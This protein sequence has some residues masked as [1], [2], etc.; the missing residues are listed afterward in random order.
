MHKRSSLVVLFSLL[1]VFFVS[2]VNVHAQMWVPMQRGIDAMVSDTEVIVSTIPVTPAAETAWE[3]APHY[4]YKFCPT[5]WT[6][7]EALI[8]FPGAYVPPEAYAPVARD[9]AAAGYMTFV[10]PVPYGVAI[11]NHDRASQVISDNPQVSIWSVGG[12]SLGGVAASQFAAAS[13]L[14]DGV[15]LWASYPFGDMSDISPRF[16]SIYGMN[17]GISTPDEIDGFMPNHPESTIWV[18]LEGANH[19]QFG[20]YYDNAHD[21]GSV[22]GPFVQPTPDPGDN[23]ATIT[24]EE[25]H[26]DMVEATLS[27]LNSLSLDNPPVISQ[28][29]ITFPDGQ[30]LSTDSGAPTVMRAMN[31]I[32]WIFEDDELDCSGVTA[33]LKYRAAGSSDPMAVLQTYLFNPAAGSGAFTA[34]VSTLGTGS[35]ECQAVLTDCAGNVTTSP[36]N[37]IIVDMPPEITST[38]FSFDTGETLSTDPANPTSM[39]YWD[40]VQ[41][42]PA[43]DEVCGDM[44]ISYQYREIGSGNEMKLNVIGNEENTGLYNGEWAI[45][46]HLYM[47]DSFTNYEVQAVVTDCSDQ[48]ATSDSYYFTRVEQ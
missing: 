48:T 24:H 11:F 13:S 18:P 5:D 30:S 21:N 47:I 9:I 31:L 36:M 10:V 20:W 37:Y 4:Y 7:N 16:V 22:T 2:G 35:Y 43:D 25:Q 6:P 32:Y 26:S 8:I 19:S 41:W 40:F 33:E 45:T 29:P 28:T 38:L 14:I 39:I 42:G 15:V 44:T 3:V 34:S 23:P 27:F 12:H 17:D 1:F 46:T